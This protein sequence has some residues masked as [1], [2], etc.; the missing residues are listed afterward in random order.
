M[1]RHFL[2]PEPGI[3]RYENC[4]VGFQD[5]I[6]AL[7]GRNGDPMAVSVYNPHADTWTERGVTPFRA[8]HA[9]CA[10]DGDAIIIAGAFGNGAFP[11]EKPLQD[12]YVYRPIQNS[13]TLVTSMPIS[14]SRGS[15]GLVVYKGK[16]YVVGGSKLGHGNG[17]AMTTAYFDEYDPMTST[18]TVMP[19]CPHQRDHAGAVV[20]HDKLFFMGGQIGGLPDFWIRHLLT[21][22]VFD[23]LAGAWTT[24]TQQL[25]YT[26]GGVSPA[27]SGD[28]VV[29]AGGEYNNV[30]HRHA[31]FFNV[32]S[33]QLLPV[34]IDMVE[35]R[36]GFQMAECRGVFYAAVGAEARPPPEKKDRRLDTIE[37][38]EWARGNQPLCGAQTSSYWPVGV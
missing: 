19:D 23:F 28:I 6:V 29:I 1:A 33:M 32:T 5:R 26:H 18:W 25:H 27:I 15:A 37:R 7:L 10:V 21:I 14:R 24:L 11:N 16:W 12:V 38:L 30:S 20:A 31:E 34:T 9:Q 17:L 8:H 35:S 2:N 22:D 36:H 4:A 13:F 3:I